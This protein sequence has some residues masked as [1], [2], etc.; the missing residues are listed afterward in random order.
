MDSKKYY[1]LKVKE[2]FFE[3]DEML[4]LQ[5]M[6]SGYL[7]SDILMKLYLRSLK[8]DGKLMYRNRIPYSPEVLAT[9]CRH[10]VGVVEKA[11]EIFRQLGL[12]EILDNGAIYMMDIQNFIG[13][14]SSEADR[15]REYRAR[16]ET[17]RITAE[18][19]RMELPEKGEEIMGTARES[20]SKSAISN[21]TTDF[22]RFWK[23][24]PRKADKGMAYKKYNARLK[25][26]FS[27]EEMLTAAAAYAA[28]CKRQRTE[29]QYIKLG[30]TFLGESTPFLDYLKKEDHAESMNDNEN[31]FRR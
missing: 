26:G 3:S 25:D 7:Y 9:V 18:E 12:I 17:D 2:D 23:V 5:R 13:K 28:Q 14:S 16:I 24:Y 1:Y 8:D 22:E 19:K 30:K 20:K 11:L 27:P 31:P 21:Y 4:I 15:K 6:P 10:E 29:I